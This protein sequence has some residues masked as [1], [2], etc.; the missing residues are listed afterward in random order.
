M[1]LK[2]SYD[3]TLDWQTYESLRTSVARKQSHTDVTRMWLWQPDGSVH[4]NTARDES[5]WQTQITAS[6]VIY[7]CVGFFC[8]FFFFKCTYLRTALWEK[9]SSSHKH[10]RPFWEQKERL[11]IIHFN[12]HTWFLHKMSQKQPWPVTVAF[13][14]FFFHVQ[15]R[16][17]GGDSS[18]F[19]GPAA[20]V[21]GGGRLSRTMLKKK[22]KKEGGA[23]HLWVN[24]RVA[25]NDQQMART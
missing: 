17:G 24:E 11:Y 21:V 6:L 23:W 2:W 8:L 25:E 1:E 15:I 3:S 14:Y 13:V 10:K 22:K 7:L 5:V 19:S 12:N 18:R 4:M 16:S 20:C 9:T